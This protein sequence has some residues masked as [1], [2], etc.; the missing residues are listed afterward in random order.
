MDKLWHKIDI[1]VVLDNLQSDETGLNTQEANRRLRVYGKNKLQEAKAENSVIIFLRQF[2]SPL[3]YIL[4]GAALI[5]LA[6]GESVDGIIIAAVLL[7]NAIIG[8][9]QEGRAQN[10]LV[11]LKKLTN[12]SATVLR[13]GTEINISANEIVPGDILIIQAGDKIPADARLIEA[14]NLQVDESSLSGE[15]MPANKAHATDDANDNSLFPKNIIFN[16]TLAVSGNGKAVIFATGTETQ[17]GKIAKDIATIDTEIPLKASIRKL[18]QMII[19]V[20]LFISLIIIAIGINLDLPIIEMFAVAVSLAVSIIPEGLPIVL[21]LVLTTGVWRM[22]KRNALVKKLQAVEALGQIKVIAVD[23]TGT[24]S[25]NEMMIQKVYI[26]GKIFDVSGNGYEPIGQVKLNDN[27]IEPLN[28]PELLLAGKIAALGANARLVFSEQENKWTIG[29]NPTEAAILVLAQKIGFHKRQLEEETPVLDEIP[30][31]FIT[32]QHVLLHKSKNENLLTTIGVPEYI[33]ENSAYYNF[34]DKHTHLSEKVK[35]K[36][37]EDLSR[38]TNQ[39]FRVVAFAHKNISDNSIDATQVINLTFGGF[40]VMADALRPEAKESIKMAHTAG[41]EVIMITG[42][43][44]NTAIAVARELGIID[45]DDLSMTGEDLDLLSETELINILGSIKVFARVNPDHKLR[46]I[47]AYKKKGVTIAMTGDGVNDAP[48]LVAADLGV[49]MG[50]IGTEVAKEASDIILLDDNFQT[51]IS[52]V[53]EGRSIYKTIQ[54]VILYLFSTSLGET[55]TITGALFLRLPL[56]ILAAQIIWLNFVTDGFL[57]VALAMEPKEKCLMSSHFRKPSRYLIDPLM[58]KRIITMSIPMAIGTL[59]LFSWYFNQDIAK[60]WT[61]SLTTLATFQWFNAWNCIHETK[62]IF[63]HSIF[64]NLYLI[65]ATI[66]VVL[67]QLLAIYTP[68][69]QNILRTVPLNLTDWLYILPV[70]ATI[71]LLEELR[72]LLTNKHT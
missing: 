64:S 15:S 37:R 72:K 34:E 5:L 4:F 32:S 47:N 26:N 41:I 52:A 55:L 19:Y 7:F 17:V 21:T 6:L 22:S 66:V 8:S 36:F 45:D 13:D 54:K 57:D 43:H 2:Q 50:K 11:A 60:A 40:F 49:A 33:I 27:I 58:L 1:A 59:V 51:I 39:G 38:L 46:I 68:F 23:K 61:I 28:Y 25:R 3:I 53:E 31:D 70:S 62:S 10:T 30:F 42:D 16:G 9:I 69:M 35:Q 14:K 44:R 71:I 18:S 63:E 65:G 56:P 24:L 29:G 20:V 12:T 48:S 67:L